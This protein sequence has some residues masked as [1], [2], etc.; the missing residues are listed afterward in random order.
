MDD[1]GDNGSDAGGDDGVAIEDVEIVAPDEDAEA[2]DAGSDADDSDA[3]AEAA[4]DD[5]VDAADIASA[6]PE[7]KAAESSR[8]PRAKP[9]LLDVSNGHSRIIV[10]APDDRVTTNI[11]QNAERAAIL[12]MRATQIEQW[13]TAFVDIAGL[14]DPHAIARKELY[15]RRCPLVVRRTVGYEP[16]GDRVVEDWCPRE[17]VLP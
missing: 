11:L 9:T 15:E 2:A 6:K 7:K 4:D 13:P 16:N 3:D 1:D 5:A 17:M 14:R 8:A 10:V 12:A